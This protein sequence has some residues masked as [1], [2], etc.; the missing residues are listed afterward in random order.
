MVDPG[1]AHPIK[2]RLDASTA[3]TRREQDA[4]P[5]NLSSVSLASAAAFKPLH[6]CGVSMHFLDDAVGSGTVG[7]RLFSSSG[8]PFTLPAIQAAGSAAAVLDIAVCQSTANSA[9][10]SVPDGTLAAV[11]SAV[12]TLCPAASCMFTCHKTGHSQMHA[13]AAASAAAECCRFAAALLQLRQVS[14]GDM[15]AALVSVK[16]RTSVDVVVALACVLRQGG[17][18]PPALR[19]EAGHLVAALLSEPKSAAPVLHSWVD[20]GEWLCPWPQPGATHATES[21]KGPLTV[22]VG[23]ALLDGL[24][25]EYCDAQLR[26]VLGALPLLQASTQRP[27]AALQDGHSSGL[28]SV[29]WAAVQCLL[30]HSVEAK[31]RATA[32]DLHLHWVQRAIQGTEGLRK[33]QEQVFSRL[34]CLPCMLP[35]GY[36]FG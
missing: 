33:G 4:V 12:A 9:G 34:L 1:L 35:W 3:S 18:V 20:D 17:L 25:P 32:R 28:T 29:N 10:T 26:P 15:K 30:A 24:M 21:V 23:S 11:L 16:A 19:A 36:R 31:E 27:P 2:T 13:A 8:T 6:A 5:E 22:P 14:P 7:S